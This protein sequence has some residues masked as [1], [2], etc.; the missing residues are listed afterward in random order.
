MSLY[1]FLPEQYLNS[2]FETGCLKLGT[3]YDFGDI[4]KHSNAR[5]DQWEGI[6]RV[7]RHEKGE[8]FLGKGFKNPVFD[9]VFRCSGNGSATLI[10]TSVIVSRHTENAYIF[11]TSRCYSD[12]LFMRWNADDKENN[13]CY[14]INN[15]DKFADAITKALIKTV[16][17][18]LNKRVIY[19]SDPIHYKSPHAEYDPCFTKSEEKYGWQ[20]ENRMVWDTIE[21]FAKISPQ[22]INVPEA[23]KYCTKFR[24]IKDGAII[25]LN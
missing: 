17:P 12:E 18:C 4:V 22:I 9:E 14:R 10:N 11:C 19:T 16:Q 6:S 7:F 21:A 2:F 3:I 5:G 20:K 13:A 8:V 24:A 15:P 1:K 25:C 23:V